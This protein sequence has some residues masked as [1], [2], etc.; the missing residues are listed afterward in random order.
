[1]ADEVTDEVILPDGAVVEQTARYRRIT[2]NAP[3]RVYDQFL[4]LQEMAKG[5]VPDSVGEFVLGLAV[6]GARGFYAQLQLQR[7]EEQ[8]VQLAGRIVEVGRD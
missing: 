5:L 4:Q 3:E 8:R 7:R 6:A 2:I 1:M